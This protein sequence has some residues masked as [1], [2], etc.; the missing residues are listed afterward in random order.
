MLSAGRAKPASRPGT[1]R[2]F[3]VSDR[4]QVAIHVL[5]VTSAG[6]VGSRFGD[7]SDSTGR[8]YRCAVTRPIFR[9]VR[10]QCQPD[11]TGSGSDLNIVKPDSTNSGSDSN[12][13]SVTQPTWWS[14]RYCNVQMLQIA[15]NIMIYTLLDVTGMLIM[16]GFLINCRLHRTMWL[17]ITMMAQPDSTNWLNYENPIRSISE[18]ATRRDKARQGKAS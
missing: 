7:V 8:S 9:S 11:P 10:L 13:N 14:T 1:D 3:L 18:M 5:S 12:I 4:V 17:R 6:R 2:L 15:V 16:M